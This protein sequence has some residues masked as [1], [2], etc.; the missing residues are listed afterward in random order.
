M[1]DDVGWIVARVVEDTDD[2][3]VDGVVVFVLHEDTQIAVMPSATTTAM[4]VFDATRSFGVI[5]TSAAPVGQ[6]GNTA[7]WATRWSA[8]FG[9]PSSV[10]RC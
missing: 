3:V 2:D 5:A 8:Y 7:T 1:V 6:Q 10:M 4:R 9:T